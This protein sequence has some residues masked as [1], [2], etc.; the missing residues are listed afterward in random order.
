MWLYNPI[1]YAL[2]MAPYYLTV[3]L[4]FSITKIVGSIRRYFNFAFIGN[5]LLY[6]NQTPPLGEGSITNLIENPL[7]AFTRLPSVFYLILVL[8]IGGSLILFL[9]GYIRGLLENQEDQNIDF[10]QRINV[11]IKGISVSLGIPILIY[12]FLV[13]SSMILTIWE[14]QILTQI[15]SSLSRNSDANSSKNVITDIA[16]KSV[17][18]PWSDSGTWGRILDRS[19]GWNP[20]EDW[21]NSYDAQW[22]YY[23]PWGHSLLWL[24]FSTLIL[25]QL[26][27]LTFYLTIKVVIST[28]VVFFKIFTIP[29]SAVIVNIDGGKQLKEEIKSLFTEGGVVFASGAIITLYSS[30]LI[31]TSHIDSSIIFGSDSNK[32]NDISILKMLASGLIKL[33]VSIGAAILCK[34]LADKIG[35]PSLKEGISRIKGAAS[36]FAGGVKGIIR[37]GGVGGVGV[38]T[39]SVIAENFAQ[40][41]T[42]NTIS[43]AINNNQE[44]SSS[45]IKQTLRN[46]RDQIASRYRNTYNKLI[47]NGSI[48]IEKVSP[49]NKGQPK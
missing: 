12:L 48:M 45:Q 34:K 3:P 10:K 43:G 32:I 7:I 22:Y 33:T 2:F 38:S 40:Q 23:K 27:L 1:L 8:T 35:D 16:S 5:A 25:A 24:I 11:F 39:A 17:V 37:R 4:I 18:P 21:Y 49:R 36:G 6:D 20:H 15:L 9:I 28:I 46:K 19:W 13:I 47:Q 26:F 30:V 29:L 31:L 44:N 41:N 14:E 42:S